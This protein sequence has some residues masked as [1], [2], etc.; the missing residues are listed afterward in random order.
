MQ[1]TPVGEFD[2]TVAG[3]GGEMEEVQ[4][5]SMGNVGAEQRTGH[6]GTLSAERKRERDWALG[7]GG[8][9]YVRRYHLLTSPS[10]SNEI[11]RC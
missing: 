8:M 4:S 2:P 6:R 9:W 1:S 5:R 11:H 7:G 10:C 3:A